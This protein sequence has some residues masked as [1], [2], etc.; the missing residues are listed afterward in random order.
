MLKKLFS[1]IDPIWY[2][3]DAVVILLSVLIIQYVFDYPPCSLCVGQ[4]FPW[5]LFFVCVVIAQYAKHVNAIKIHNTMLWIATLTM[6]GSAGFGIYLV[7]I[8]YELWHAVVS[9]GGA[10]NL[11]LNSTNLLQAIQSTTLVDC[12]SKDPII[13]GLSLPVWNAI[14]STYMAISIG[15]MA[16]IKSQK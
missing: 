1:R 8:Q 7:G 3:I 15:Y 10:V 11:Q 13:F 12:A 16:Y 6:V 14:I 2:A 4:R 5:V 9:C